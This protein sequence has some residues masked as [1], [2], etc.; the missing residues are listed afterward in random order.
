MI[1]KDSGAS[2]GLLIFWIVWK[3]SDKESKEGAKS[4]TGMLLSYKAVPL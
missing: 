2:L 3:A 4:L 1:F